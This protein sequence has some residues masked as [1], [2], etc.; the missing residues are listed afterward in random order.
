MKR[1]K[2]WG[3]RGRR[4]VPHALSGRKRISRRLY[5]LNEKQLN[6]TFHFFQFYACRNK[7]KTLFIK[8]TSQLEHAQQVKLNAL[9]SNGHRYATVGQEN[10]Q[11]VMQTSLKS[12]NFAMLY[13]RY[14]KTEIP[15]SLTGH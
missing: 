15:L 4:R 6:M 2:A 5:D 13:L 12:S 14:F 7:R 11:C 8:G 9:V 3:A 1:M 10:S